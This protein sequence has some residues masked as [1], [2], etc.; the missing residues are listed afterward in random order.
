MAKAFNVQKLIKKLGFE[1]GD[2]YFVKQMGKALL[3]TYA[4]FGLAWWCN[5]TNVFGWW[6]IQIRPKVVAKYGEVANKLKLPPLF[7]L[8]PSFMYHY[9]R[10]LLA[11]TMCKQIYPMDWSQMEGQDMIGTMWEDDFTLRTQFP[12]FSLEDKARDAVGGNDRNQVSDVDQEE[13]ELAHLYER[14][15]YPYPG[16]KEAFDEFVKSGGAI[17]TTVGPKGF[18]D[19]DKDTE[20]LQKQLQSQKF[21]HEAQKLWFRM[22]NEVIQELQEKGF[23]ME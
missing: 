6:N 13:T 17:G 18:I 20:N 22:R 10:K 19:S 2:F 11:S 4:I 12:Y 1:K 23:D 15:R 16:D 9:L 21:E 8:I 14:I 7:R 5:E 3:C